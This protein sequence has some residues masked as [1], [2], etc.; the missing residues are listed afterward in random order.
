M[1]LCAATAR[2]GNLA[3]RVV[4]LAN[5][6]S[7][8]SVRI[9]RHY[10]AARGVP[11]ANI[12]ALPLPDVETVTW[13]VFVRTLWE[14]LEDALVSQ[15]WIDAL[16]MD[17]K[18][19][20]GRRKYAV[21][22]HRIGA[23]VVCRGVPLKIENDPG[24]YAEVPPQTNH[25]EFRTNE[26]AVDSEL[27]LLAQPNHPINA[28]VSNPLYGNAAPTPSE[29]ARVVEV[30]R[31]DGPTA[32]QALHL[33]DL[34]LAAEKSGLA[35]RAYVDIA[36]PNPKGDRWLES[37]A[38]IL[39]SL[40][41]DTAVR[42][43]PGTLPASARCD[44]PALYFGWYASDLN[45]PF[46]LPGFRFPAGAVAVH[47]HSFSAH[48]LRSDHDGWCGPLVAHGVTATVGNVYE[49]YL[50]LVHRPDL[51]LAALA[52]GSTLADAAYYALPVLSWQSIVIG[53]PL[54][55]P[56]SVAADVQA[57]GASTLPE[58][59]RGYAV[60]RRMNLL[61][62]QGRPGDAAAAG[63]AGMRTAPNLALALDVLHRSQGGADQ[64]TAVDDVYRTAVRS[65][66]A[67]S[68][69]GLLHE[70]ADV[71]ARSGR[72]EKAAEVR[73]RLIA[74]PQVPAPLRLA[75]GIDAAPASAADPGAR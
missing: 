39:S 31:L 4:I 66:V 42:R 50:E 38:A 2:A 19:G 59:S 20:V 7:P 48:T 14:P 36:G 22:G 49:P 68:T 17:L 57:L 10:A 23:L 41:F 56:F 37:T 71:L 15:G 29:R 27:S 3:A 55:R 47:I 30:S 51:L 52:H 70:A 75:W 25:A 53:D 28:W 26:G 34:A 18:D 33:V 16:A 11:A 65:A 63:I 54:Y 40:G 13:G 69:W 21:S 43:G 8:D 5:A 46:A 45:G 1:L 73:A 64:T 60:I 44:A 32:D 72:P 58:E 67:A 12:I 9:A 24:L 74:D 35:G 62:A 6:D 61:G